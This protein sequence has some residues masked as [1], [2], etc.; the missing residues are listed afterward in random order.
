MILTT[1]RD[2]HNVVNRRELQVILSQTVE[3]P[4]LWQPNMDHMQNAASMASKTTPLID[5][6]KPS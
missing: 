2:T 4:A 3:N 5:E 1:I 6:K